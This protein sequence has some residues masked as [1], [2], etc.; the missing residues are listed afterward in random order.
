LGALMG[1]I[2]GWPMVLMA[3]FL[4]YILGSIV[5]IGLI[6]AGKKKWGSEV[7][8]GVFLSTATVVALFWGQQIVD[9][10]FNLLIF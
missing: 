10:Y 2:L 5:G 4:A 9:W 3:L 1:L 7:P 6:L 8:F